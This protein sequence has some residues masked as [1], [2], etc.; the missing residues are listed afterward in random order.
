MYLNSAGNV[1][2]QT[3]DFDVFHGE[4]K[5]IENVNYA[6]QPSYKEL[7]APAMSRRMAKGIKMS[8]Y[9]ANEALQKSE[10][11]ELDAIIVGTA[12]GCIEDSEKFLGSIVENQEE[13]LTPTSFIQSTHNTVAAQIA[14]HWQCKAYNFTYVNGSN[15]FESALF[16]AFMQIKFQDKNQILVGGVDEIAPY[17]LELYSLIGKVKKAEDSIDFK[18]P[19]TNGMTYSEGATFFLV[20]NEKKSESLAEIADVQIWN[21]FPISMEAS[22]ETFLNRNQLTKDEIDVVFLGVNADQS[23]QAFYEEIQS[24]FSNSSFGYYQHI[25]GSYETASAFGLKMAAEVLQ[26]QTFP[27]ILQYTESKHKKLENTL[28]VHHSNG[29]DIGFILLKKC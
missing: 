1:L 15:S 14:L 21:Q 10:N 22:V 24:V 25:S 4:P 8:I 9:A 28:L 3:T 19:K 17:T 7:I 27:K 12:L 6:Q 2:I 16:D 23:Q 13:Y 11:Q 5:T 26:K 20:S 18:N 29:T